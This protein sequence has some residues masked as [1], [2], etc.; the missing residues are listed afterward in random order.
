MRRKAEKRLKFRGVGPPGVYAGPVRALRKLA[1]VVLSVLALAAGATLAVASGGGASHGDSGKG[2]YG[3][4]PGCG[5][6]KP[7]WGWN[8]DCPRPRLHDR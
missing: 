3:V 6:K 1:V 8:R 2:Q 7:E 5:P 4:K